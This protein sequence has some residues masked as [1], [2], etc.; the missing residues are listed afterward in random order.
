MARGRSKAF[1]KMPVKLPY[2][3]RYSM[4]FRVFAA[5]DACLRDL[6]LPVF[7]LFEPLHKVTSNCFVEANTQYYG[8]DLRASAA[9]SLSD[10]C[11]LCD[12]ETDCK[13]W[14]YY[15]GNCYRK[16]SDLGRLYTSALASG[17]KG[18]MRWVRQCV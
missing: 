9:A 6:T 16:S 12:S 1:W 2:V 14:T 15:L 4:L 5:N 7:L 8:Y 18:V 11:D 10:C 3:V 17:Y 13:A